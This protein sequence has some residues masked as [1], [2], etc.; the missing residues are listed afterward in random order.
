MGKKRFVASISMSSFR[1][2]NV[3]WFVYGVLFTLAVVFYVLYR[4]ESKHMFRQV[5]TATSASKTTVEDENGISIPMQAFPEPAWRTPSTLAVRTVTSTPFARFEIHKVRT[6]S[7]KI[8]N[9]WLWTDERAHVNILVHMKKEN[10]YML[11]HQMK[12]GLT[13]P[14]YA[15]VGGLFNPGDTPLTCAKRELLEEAGL[16]SNEMVYLGAYRVQVNRGGGILH[17]F[18]AR[19]CIKSHTWKP[20]DDYETQEKRYLDRDE[21][22][23]VMLGGEMGEV[24]WLATVATALLHEEYHGTVMRNRSL[25]VSI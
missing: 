22:L 17:A 11:F 10:K 19:N 7:G 13:K 2:V 21:L 18:Y 8:V 23:K 20:S 6:E 9:D 25:T 14:H 15:T 1:R 16:E 5:D 24:Q 4:F 12:Y 3:L